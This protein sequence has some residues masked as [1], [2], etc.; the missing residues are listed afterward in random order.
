MLLHVT[1]RVARSP[2]LL[3]TVVSV[4]TVLACVVGLGLG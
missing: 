1:T 4:F 3:S 2:I